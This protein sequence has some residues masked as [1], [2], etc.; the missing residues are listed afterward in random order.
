VI[1]D[2]TLKKELESS[3]KSESKENDVGLLI[4]MKKIYVLK[5]VD[6]LS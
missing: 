4:S 5:R 1:S 2:V 6:C 3:E